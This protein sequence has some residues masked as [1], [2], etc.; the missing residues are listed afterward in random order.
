M[1]S[2]LKYARIFGFISAFILC[3]PFLLRIDIIV[4]EPSIAISSLKAFFQYIFVCLLFSV[5]FLILSVVTG[6]WVIRKADISKET[7]ISRVCGVT[8]VYLPYTY[9]F[10]DLVMNAKVGN[11]PIGAILYPISAPVGVPILYYLGF[12][13]AE[14][15][16]KHKRPERDGGG[17]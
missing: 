2:N 10:F 11:A 5:P 9:G 16:L 15:Y 12:A 13:I 8:F 3:T 6:I 7:F 4:G 17:S 1:E 14:K